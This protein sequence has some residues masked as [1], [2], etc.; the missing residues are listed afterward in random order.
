MNAA[1]PELQSPVWSIVKQLSA[2]R[3]WSKFA[4]AKAGL[5]AR[6]HGPFRASLN[7]AGS[8]KDSDGSC[9]TMSIEV[10]K[11]AKHAAATITAAAAWNDAVWCSGAL[12]IV[13]KVK[14]MLHAGVLSLL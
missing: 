13:E 9:N 8:R 3:G 14:H 2:A 12:C 10:S 7:I 11:I 5:V 1:S 6:W 4:K